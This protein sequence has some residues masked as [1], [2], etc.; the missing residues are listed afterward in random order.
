[1]RIAMLLVATY[2]LIVT[3]PT[4]AHSAGK[5]LA[6]KGQEIFQQL[7]IGCHGPDGRAQSEMG[8]TVQA[9][10]LTSAVVQDQRNS[11]LLK[12]IRNGRGKMPSWA[13]RLNDSEIHAVL[14]YVRGLRAKPQSFLTRPKS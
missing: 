5:D 12:V 3:I 14:A 13:S 8:K 11:E 9:A 6:E 4:H 7:C 10:D 2:T 1:M